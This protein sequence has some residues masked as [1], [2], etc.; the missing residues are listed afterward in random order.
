MRGNPTRPAAAKGGSVAETAG[1][2]QASAVGGV[3]SGF[4]SARWREVCLGTARTV[5]R[6]FRAAYCVSPEGPSAVTLDSVGGD[7]GVIA[8]GVGRLGGERGIDIRHGSVTPW[9]WWAFNLVE[10]Q[11]LVGDRS[12][13]DSGCLVSFRVREV[14]FEPPP[15]AVEPHGEDVLPGA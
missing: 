12:P 7:P 14:L 3:A 4:G 5:A 13:R 1:V 15:P 10:C 11:V 6:W 8:V 2:D 9:K